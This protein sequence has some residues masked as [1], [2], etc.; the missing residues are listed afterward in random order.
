[1]SLAPGTRL[2]PYEIVA[3]IGAGGMGEVY[4]AR[5]TRLER[6]VAVKVLPTHLSESA[7]V[8]QRFE[9]EAKTISSLSHPHICA[10][11]DVGN[12]DGVE[13][14]VMEYLEGDTLSERLTRGPL[15]FDQVLRYG[16][17]IADALDKAHR[18]GIVHRDL[19]PGNVMLT[20]SGVKLLDFGLAKAVAPTAARS[21]ASLTALPTQ[22]G[23]DLTAEG[24]ILG[25]FQYMAPE[26]L[27]G[28]DADARTDIFAFGAVLYEMATGKKAFAGRSQASLISSIM[29]SEPPPVSAVAP[30]TPPAFDKVVRTCLAKDPDDRW[31]TAHDIAVQ[32]R[33]IQEGGAA[34]SPAPSIAR[35]R[36]VGRVLPWIVAAVAT[37]GLAALLV[38]DRLRPPPA[39]PVT[40]LT[41]L[42]PEKTIFTPPGE[43]SSSQFALSP[44]GRSIVFVA[45][46]TNGRP[47]LWVRPFDSFQS[48]S[49]GGTEDA[50]HPFWSPD[51]RSIAF[52]TPAA[53]KR[54]EVSGGAPQKLCDAVA[55]RG[56]TWNS[57]G[58]ILFT[59]SANTPVF[60][61]SETGGEPVAATVLDAGRGEDRHR[62]PVFLPDG[63]RFLYWARAPRSDSTGVYVA[64]LDSPNGRLVVKAQA[65]GMYA[66]GRLLTVQQGLLVSYPFDE[67]TARVT[68][69]PIRIAD[70]IPTGNPPGYAPFSVAGREALAFSSPLAKS[71]Q[72]VWFDRSGRRVGTVGE[73]GDY[74]TPRLSPD[75]K[76]LAVAIREESKSATDLWLFDFGRQ[77]WSRF[78]FDP[79]S[80]RA[81]LWSPDGARIVFSSGGI[82]SVLDLFEKPSSGSGE[83]RLAIGSSFDKFPTDWTH[84]GR[85]V[86][87]HTFGG[88]TFWDIWVAPMDGG[89]PF[90]FLATKYTEVQGQISPDGRWMVYTSDESGRLEIYVTRFP[91]KQGHWQISS[92]GGTQPWWRGDGREIFY[93]GPDQTLMS[94]GV[95][96][97]DSFESSAPKPLLKASFPMLIPAYWSNYCPTSDGQRFLVSEL[98]T[99]TASTPIN[100][101]LNWTAALKK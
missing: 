81:P 44:D 86:V 83:S 34:I 47:L 15:P 82:N 98:V 90:P 35:R 41:I 100:V 23:V 48:A 91:D 53:L 68:G 75:G 4:K 50:L 33:W 71:R 87:Y 43:L 45:N 22:A 60:R 84:D 6:T 31:Q 16:C 99:E 63:K 97:G 72:L 39:V 7:D 57:S 38:R 69:P 70:S 101:V 2:G 88:K 64:S 66:A 37:A 79:A 30:M 77:T 95:Q 9:R 76:K 85:F 10:L 11:Y 59:H 52:F 19:K 92:T 20:K 5:D 1:V 28:R 32:M 73:V 58:V 8:R 21:G 42:P 74:S 29:G 36:T 61:V 13:F 96:A 14:L 27:E 94:V 49:L 62:Y 3:P 17:E 78:T 93:L 25:T 56:G 54:V 46:S 24:T 12:Q 18:Q 26:Q 89:K 65:L 55:G 40:R 80:D 67:K 51:G